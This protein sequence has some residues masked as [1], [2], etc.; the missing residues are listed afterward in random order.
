MGKNSKQSRKPPAVAPSDT[1][2]PEMA[3]ELELLIKVPAL[4]G[5]PWYAVRHADIALD[6]EQAAV[7][8]RIFNATR[9][10]ELR[11][12]RYVQSPQDAVRYVFDALVRAYQA[13]QACDGK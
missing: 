4:T 11:S 8:K 12:G 13:A 10:K 1:P 2:P 3:T 7:L 9:G 6:M 5:D